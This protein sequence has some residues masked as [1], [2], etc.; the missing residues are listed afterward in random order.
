MSTVWALISCVLLGTARAEEG[1]DTVG[2]AVQLIQQQLPEPLDE[3]VLY[4]AALVGIT[5][6][7]N[8]Q[9]GASIH[10][11]LTEQEHN[12][13]EAWLRGERDGIGAIYQIISGQGVLLEEIFPGGPAAAAGMETGDLIVAIDDQPFTGLSDA[14]IYELTSQAAQRPSITLDVM[15]VDQKSLSRF[16]VIRGRYSIEAVSQASGSAC[17]IDLLFFSQGSAERLASLLESVPED[18]GLLLDLRDNQGGLLDE[19]LAAASLFLEGGAVITYRRRTNGADEALVAT[20]NRRWSQPVVVLINERTAGAAEVF[21]G[22]LQ[23]H[24]AANLV[25]TTTAGQA[26][27]PGYY[28]LGSGLVLQL[29]DTSLRSPS[30]RSWAGTGLIPDIRV[31]P[32]QQRLSLSTPGV[33]PDIQHDTGRQLITCP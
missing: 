9:S 2:E 33:P 13:I 28:P 30:G 5:N 20:G 32:L 18:S 11:V 4:Q 16:T 23:D 21:A 3:D 1:A 17:A 29:A 10:G 7:L 24:R 14:L 19:A 25:G 31:E 12:Q 8:Q 27:E 26:A 22:A 15:R 6:F